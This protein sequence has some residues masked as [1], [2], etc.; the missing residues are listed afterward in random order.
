MFFNFVKNYYARLKREK[1][2]E[3]AKEAIK[4]YVPKFITAEQYEEITGE[5]F[6]A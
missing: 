2:E 1:G 4:V 5:A 3:V 6:N